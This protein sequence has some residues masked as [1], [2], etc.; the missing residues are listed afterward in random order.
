MYFFRFYKDGSRCEKCD[1]SCE[2]CTGPGPESCRV[3]PPPLLELRGT[4]L[5]V[6]R[7][8]RHFYELNEICKQCHT[9][10]QT[11][12][13]MNSTITEQH[14]NRNMSVKMLYDSNMRIVGNE[15][16]PSLQTSLCVSG[17]FRQVLAI[18]FAG[19][20]ISTACMCVCRCLAS[21]LLDVR[22]G[23]HLKR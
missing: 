3:C 8:P 1:Q 16:D 2:L 14:C 21:E 18:R 19:L 12:T 22:L 15:P 4:K 7:C 23:Q 11:C 17:S 13:G 5:C 6:E 10:C 20:I 9:S